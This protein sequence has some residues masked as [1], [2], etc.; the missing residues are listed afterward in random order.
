MFHGWDR[1]LEDRDQGR[2]LWTKERTRLRGSLRSRPMW[3][4]SRQRERG[5][6][7]ATERKRR[8]HASGRQAAGLMLSLG[9]DA[10][11]IEM[12]Q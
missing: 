2:C 3:L 12:N 9:G 7:V 4:R 8:G 6:P 11:A 10:V 5:R 1:H